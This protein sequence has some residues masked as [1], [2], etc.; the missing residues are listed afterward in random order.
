[1]LAAYVAALCDHPALVRGERGV[2][3]IVA[4]DQRQADIIF[5][6]IVANFEG[7]PILRQL[8]ESQTVAPCG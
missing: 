5:G 4:P 3:L 8:I 1:M 2:L 6:Y 7:S